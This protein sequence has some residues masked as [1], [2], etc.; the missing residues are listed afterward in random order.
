MFII[1]RFDQN[2]FKV[3]FAHFCI[4]YPT[5]SICVSLLLSH[6]LFVAQKKSH[7]HFTNFSHTIWWNI[8]SINA[9]D[10]YV[11]AKVNLQVPNQYQNLCTW[12]H[13]QKNRDRNQLI[14]II[15]KVTIIS[16]PEL[17]WTFHR[18]YSCCSSVV[19]FPHLWHVCCRYFYI[20]VVFYLFNLY[21]FEFWAFNHLNCK[22]TYRVYLYHI[23]YACI[24]WVEYR[25]PCETIYSISFY[26]TVLHGQPS[27]I[28]F[29]QHDSDVNVTLSKLLPS[30]AM[31]QI[32]MQR[33]RETVTTSVNAEE[34]C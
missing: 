29:W 24:M 13:I 33:K 11:F 18:F 15:K 28:Q 2:W 1:K 7:E 10:Y 3:D 23:Y 30:F 4:F 14:R 6:F 5:P 17:S 20:F 25:I 19:I 34:R 32:C 31:V 26:N 27:V 8:R 22:C 9:N 16:C 21:G 12:F